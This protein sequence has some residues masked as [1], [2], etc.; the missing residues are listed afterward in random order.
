MA[1]VD[2]GSI[3]DSIEN[4]DPLAVDLKKRTRDALQKLGVP[5][6][7]AERYASIV[8]FSV[9]LVITA[10]GLIIS[11]AVNV[12]D[13]LLR[14]FL[15]VLTKART[16]TVAEQVD[17]SASVL[18]EFL[19]TEIDPAHLKTG[20]NADQT[21]A[22]ARAI[23]QALLG[24]LTTEFV[25]QGTVTPETAEAAAQTFSGYAVNFAVQNTMIGTLADALSF[26]FLEDFRELGVEVARNLGLGRLVRQAVQPLI[27][28]AIAEPYDQQLRKRYHQD[29]LSEDHAVKAFT[30]QMLTG[31]DLHEVLARKGYA[32]NL[33]GILID[34][35]SPK[36][37]DAELWTLKRNGRVDDDFAAKELGRDGVSPVTAGYK[38]LAK[39][40]ERQGAIIDAIKA[41]LATQYVNGL[42][43]V[44]GYTSLINQLPISQG[45][46]DLE[47]FLGNIRRQVPRAFLTWSEVE[48]SF[49]IGA[50]DLNYVD[51][52]L[53]RRGYSD[54]DQIVKELLLLQKLGAAITKEQAA[55]A[56]K[57]RKANPPPPPTPQ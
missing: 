41:E 32:D 28:N 9:G 47:V 22:A 54:E 10:A 49:I 57:A 48:N 56:K 38:F 45:E 34:L 37:S 53:Q 4:S 25:P 3:L 27:R 40:L 14:V 43:D 5:L 35:I 17:I 26:H 19:A 6:P 42:L 7:Q 15:R 50:V 44:D 12:A 8:G 20:K 52:W 13:P 51:A 31:T 36:L 30:G 29:L 18:S 2:I 33:H 55:A 21:L 1:N 46:K 16:D 11:I 39:D 23:G 24:R